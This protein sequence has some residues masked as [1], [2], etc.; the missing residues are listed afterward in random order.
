M[1]RSAAAAPS[2]PAPPAIA[3]TAGRSAAGL[4]PAGG[5]AGRGDGDAERRADRA[6]VDAVA[7]IRPSDQRQPAEDRQQQQAGQR[8]FRLL[9]VI[10]PLNHCHASTAR[11]GRIAGPQHRATS[12]V[13]RL[14]AA[15]ASSTMPRAGSSPGSTSQRRHC[16]RP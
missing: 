15:A 9:Q 7:A 14:R 11:V 5:R 4:S 2:A 16:Q 8:P 13:D 3:R 1:P 12:T 6:G 10:A